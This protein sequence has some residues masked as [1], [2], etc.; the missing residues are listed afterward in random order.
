MVASADAGNDGPDD[1]PPGVT[2]LLLD[3]RDGKREAF[4]RLFPAIY[5]ELRRIARGQ[6]NREREGHTLVTTALVHEA[7]IRL[8]DV[9]RV[10]WRDRVH[11]LSMAARVM[12]R[13]LIDYARQQNALR[14]GGGARRVTLDEALVGDDPRIETLVAIDDALVRLGSLN[15]RLVWV[16]EARRSRATAAARESP[17]ARLIPRF[18][19]RFS[20]PPRRNR[21]VI[22]AQ[23]CAGPSR[24]TRVCAFPGGKNAHASRRSARLSVFALHGG[25]LAQALQPVCNRARMARNIA[26]GPADRTR[27]CALSRGPECAC[28]SARCA[29]VRLPTPR[30]PDL[31]TRHYAAGD[32][33]T[34]PPGRARPA[35]SGFGW[36]QPRA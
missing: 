33:A 3:C 13:I 17:D 4:D 28:V 29:I 19:R 12:R 1:S 6:L 24:Q 5:E 27:V 8:V 18:V 16:V 22:G 23:N 14:R 10:E 34:A 36:R 2:E 30:R 26:H 11:F 32:R 35:A 15:P 21:C 7:Y 31:A 9:T 25:R 20:S